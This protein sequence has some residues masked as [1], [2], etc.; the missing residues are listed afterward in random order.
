MNTTDGMAEQVPDVAAL[1]AALDATGYL[2]DE[3]L[4][5]ALFLAARM[6]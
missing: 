1:L 4:A 6:G 3:A 5:T 2:A